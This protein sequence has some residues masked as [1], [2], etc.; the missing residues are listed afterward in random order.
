MGLDKV[1]GKV[2]IKKDINWTDLIEYAEGEILAHREKIKEIRKS[3]IFFNKQVDSGI[4]FSTKKD[5]R[6]KE[7]S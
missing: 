4:P 6:H 1:N 7:L 3:F 2:G 5:D